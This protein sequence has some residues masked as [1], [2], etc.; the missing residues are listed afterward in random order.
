MI[1]LLVGIAS[2]GGVLFGY[3]TGTA[4]GARH[5]ARTAW[6]LDGRYLVLLSTGTLI[7]AMVG[8]ATSR[9]RGCVALFI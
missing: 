6:A 4:A 5:L 9:P 8:A 1:Y 7:G 2:L 3:Q